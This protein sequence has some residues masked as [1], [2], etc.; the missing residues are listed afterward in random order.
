MKKLLK[1]LMLLACVFVASNLK[2]DAANGE[3]E[4]DPSE[5]CS[6]CLVSL[7]YKTNT[8][9]NLVDA[10]GQ[11][12]LVDR[13]GN[14]VN[15]SDRPR[16]I[17]LSDSQIKILPC[18]HK[19]HKTC[20]DRWLSNHNTCPICRTEITI[21]QPLAQPIPQETQNARITPVPYDRNQIDCTILTTEGFAEVKNYLQEHPEV[22]KLILTDNTRQIPEDFFVGLNNLKDLSLSYNQLTSLPS[23][24]VNLTSLR[25]LYL[26][27]NELTSL[28]PTIG[29]LTSLRYLYLEHNE[30]TSLPSSIVNL[31]SLGYLNL[32]SNQLTSLPT[33]IGNLRSLESLYLRFNQLT[34]LPESIVNLSSLRT[35]DLY[36]NQLTSLPTSI[37]NLES[38]ERLDLRRNQL[39]S[40]PESIGN[41][42]RLIELD[43]SDNHIIPWPT[44][45]INQIQRQNEDISIAGQDSQT[46]TPQSPQQ[47]SF[48][49][50]IGRKIKF[51]FSKIFKRKA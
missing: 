25:Y 39:A 32:S 8:D 10:Q 5:E 44:E 50:R 14:L 41:L 24:I 17:P 34:F 16:L 42:S 38:L 46:P 49:K 26:E 31:R 43:L 7:N 27:H 21:P 1:F 22:V 36:R 18:G 12:M 37:G 4:K 35:L 29:N 13:E 15:E 45:L 9:G 20:I 48:F 11:V 47:V 19:F 51:A 28:P 30:L 33:S 6:V 23:S 40:L 3:Q 2:L